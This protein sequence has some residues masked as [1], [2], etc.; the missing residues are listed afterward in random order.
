M[1]TPGLGKGIEQ[2]RMAMLFLGVVL[3][4]MV[5]TAYIQYLA[6]VQ[7]QKAIQ[8]PRKSVWSNDQK[9]EPDNKTRLISTAQ[10]RLPSYE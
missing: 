9:C 1:Y 10:S 4:I 8:L 2:L 7:E 5:A 3:V 6:M